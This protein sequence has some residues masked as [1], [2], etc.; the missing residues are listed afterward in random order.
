MKKIF[1]IL[2]CPVIFLTFFAGISVCAEN[3]L[4]PV[5]AD[6]IK[7]GTYSVEVESSSSMFRVV[8]C[9]IVV[10]DDRITAFM[11]MSGQGY[12]LVFPGTGDEALAA[13]SSEY[14]DFTLNDEGQ[15]VFS[16]EIEA[17]DKKINCAAWSIKKEKW[18]D[19]ELVFKSE[20]LPKNA[21]KNSSVYVI[22]IVPAVIIL[23]A[24]VF[25]ILRK[26]RGGK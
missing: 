1:A 4:K 13:D 7:N 3:G 24:A 18:Y 9:K 25:F 12:G 15:K 16:L 11:T 19:R 14:I 5:Y 22:I 20:N 21:L 17:L 26:K 23:A 2:F 10:A 6:K 8:D